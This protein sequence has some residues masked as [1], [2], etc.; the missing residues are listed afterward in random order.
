MY[1]KK[2]IR[3]DFDKINDKFINQIYTNLTNK[4]I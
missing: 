3:V 1:K 4:K 2:I